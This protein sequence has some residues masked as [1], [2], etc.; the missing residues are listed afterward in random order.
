MR[1][2]RLQDRRRCGIH[3]VDAVVVEGVSQP[4]PAALGHRELDT[5]AEQQRLGVVIGIFKLGLAVFTV[6]AEG[7]ITAQEGRLDEGDPA[8]G[9]VEAERDVEHQ[10]LAAAQEV[11]LREAR[12]QP[13]T[14]GEVV[15]RPEAQGA[16]G[17]FLDRDIDD[18]LIRGTA[19]TGAHLGG[20]K[21]V[22]GAD[23]FGRLAD[24][25]RVE[26]IA[27]DDAELAADHP[28]KRAGVA[29][30]VDA[31]D[32]DAR[33]PHQLEFDI[34]RQLAVVAADHRLDPHEGQPLAGGQ[35]FHPRDGV[36][37]VLGGIDLAAADT[38]ERGEFGGVHTGQIGGGG[39]F[40]ETELL[41][42]ADVEGDE[43]GVALARKFRGHRE[44]LE[45][46]IA[47]RLVE[48][49]QDPA[50][51]GDA[52]LDEGIGPDEEAQRPGLLG[53]QHP[54]QAGIRKRAVAD[55][56]DALHLHHPALVDLED[57]VHPVA[58]ALDQ[59]R[60]D[61]G[62]HPALLAVGLDKRVG[63]A[64]DL[65][66]VEH[67]A[68]LGGDDLERLLVGQPRV[69]LD[70]DAVD[71]GI[72]HHRDHQPRPARGKG[73]LLEQARGEDALIGGVQLCGGDSLPRRDAG[74][75]EH[76]RIG[77][78]LVSGDHDGG[79]TVAL[80]LLLGQR[81]RRRQ[82]RGQNPQKKQRRGKLPDQVPICAKTPIPAV[83]QFKH[84]P[85]S[86]QLFPVRSE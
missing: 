71:G 22:Q 35:L 36:V 82:T 37:H 2:F 63:V 79:E 80:R 60:P 33:P 23:A 43:E 50:V 4:Q 8:I 53:F 16:G 81:G 51:E 85:R 20:G 62:R 45:I 14:G 11:T 17:L 65:G 46:D 26:G 77:D 40:T 1:L 54:A 12:R 30:D 83:T 9:V 5:W 18:H 75:A 57:H 24:L 84:R 66:G 15:G 56:G 28:V 21:Q 34:Q 42:L 72:F 74:I 61:G 59:P 19:F 69:A 67:P 31:L 73:D 70:R 39:D 41:A 47:A 52:I 38:G 44:H 55:E 27:L 64:L 25:A 48:I 58:R 3:V 68:R 78:P 49:A 6:E 76:R 29:G 10:R 86:K 32:E 13:D 7:Q